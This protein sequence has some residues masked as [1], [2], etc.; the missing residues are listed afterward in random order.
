M[1]AHIDAR[2]AQLGLDL[3]APAR[4]VGAYVPFV[5]ADRLIF[6]SGQLCMWEG[7]VRY[8]GRVGTDITLEDGQHAARLSALNL[9]AQAR[10][11]CGGDLNRIARVV[12]LGG[13]VTCDASFADHPK[14]IDGA[15]ALMVEV[16]GDAGRHSRFA[17]GAP[18][19]PLGASVE[20]EG[21]FQTG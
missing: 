9:L 13:F 12:R 3:P 15:S 16:F 19:L 6:V 21:V 4:P 20:V 11:A 7:Q 8:S 1:T 10:E 5:I 17:V 18:S 14:V 2:L